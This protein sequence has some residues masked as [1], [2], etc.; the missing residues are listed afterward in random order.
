A[1]SVRFAG[2]ELVGLPESRMRRIRGRRIGL[3]PQDPMSNLNPVTRVGQQIG[4]T[5]LT[6]GMATK[7]DVGAAV[8][9]VME[10]AGIPEPARRAKQYPHELSGGLRQRVLIAIGLACRPQLLIADEP[11][12]DQ[13]VRY[14]YL[15]DADR[16]FVAEH[17]GDRN[18]LGV[19]V[20]LG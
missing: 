2:E 20:Q 13:L 3:V 1:G 12:S 11:T 19:A 15:D 7:K 8:V 5:L 10:R 17:R 16:A 18:R 4:E 6:H 14:F 9:E